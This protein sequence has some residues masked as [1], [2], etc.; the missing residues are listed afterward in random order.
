M[1]LFFFTVGSV[2]SIVLIGWVSLLL[3]I[4]K[5]VIERNGLTNFDGIEMIETPKAC[6]I[7]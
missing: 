4:C 5:K 2:L 7:R 6:N 3:Q 1:S